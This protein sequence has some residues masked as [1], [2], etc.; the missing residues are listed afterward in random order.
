M[1]GVKIDARYKKEVLRSVR[2]QAEV[3]RRK[4]MEKSAEREG[5]LKDYQDENFAYIVGY[6]NWG[7]PYG[8]T[9][10]EFELSESE[11]VAPDE[12]IDVGLD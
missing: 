9:W 12:T 1:L 2:G 7:F 5:L 3:K 10:E 6:T 4:R 8:V 11:D